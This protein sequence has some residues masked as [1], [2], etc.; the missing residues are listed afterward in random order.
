MYLAFGQTCL[1]L[2]SERDTVELLEVRDVKKQGSQA[3]AKPVIPMEKLQRDAAGLAQ[4]SFNITVMGLASLPLIYYPCLRGTAWSW[5]YFFGR[6]FFRNLPKNAP[7]AGII[8]TSALVWQ[9]ASS[10]FMMV[11]LWELNSKDLGK[12]ELASKSEHISKIALLRGSCEFHACAGLPC[13]GKNSQAD[14][15]HEYGEN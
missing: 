10:S 14:Q 1:H 8:H 2:Y 15:V 9:G 12:A 4:R 13:R 6:I 5:T 11:F 3:E 7:P